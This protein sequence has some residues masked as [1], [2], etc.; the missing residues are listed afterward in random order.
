V[1]AVRIEL[2]LKRTWA[3]V[4]IA[5]Y[6]RG[7]DRPAFLLRKC[8]GRA[9]VRLKDWRAAGGSAEAGALQATNRVAGTKPGDRLAKRLGK[10]GLCTRLEVVVPFEQSCNPTPATM[11]FLAV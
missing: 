9:E 8:V 4:H 10:A 7:I 2:F 3:A 6:H 11:P 1:L 5:R